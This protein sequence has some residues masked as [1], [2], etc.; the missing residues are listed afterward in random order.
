MLERMIFSF[1]R[2]DHWNEQSYSKGKSFCLH[3]Y[4]PAQPGVLEKMFIVVNFVFV[5]SLQDD[6]VFI[7]RC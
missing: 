4:K 2:G 3:M 6:F 7:A 5:D 1:F